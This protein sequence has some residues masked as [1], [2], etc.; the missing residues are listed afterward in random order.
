MVEERPQAMLRVTM[1]SA[2]SHCE[3]IGEGRSAH[4]V[5]RCDV[6]AIVRL[7]YPVSRRRA[8]A[9]GSCWVE[10]GIR[11]SRPDK[12]AE[13]IRGLSR[14]RE[15]DLWGIVEVK[16]R[17]WARQFMD[18]AGES[19]KYVLGT[20]GR[21]SNDRMVILYDTDR[22]ALLARRSFSM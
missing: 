8:N 17:S 2:H 16:S 1:G 18:A 4:D 3:R 10:R 20:T 5:V 15:I 12:I 7:V 9:V 21:R 22:L 11:W 14:D 19:F 13:R 6:D